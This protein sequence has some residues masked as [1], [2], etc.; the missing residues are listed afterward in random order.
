MP[1][2]I[3]VEIKIEPYQP[4]LILTHCTGTNFAWSNEWLDF[5]ESAAWL[6]VYQKHWKFLPAL[7]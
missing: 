6:S 4:P 3:R 2:N 5:Y 1:D 7:A